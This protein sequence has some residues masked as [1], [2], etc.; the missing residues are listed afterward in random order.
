M[1]A[2]TI[3]LILCC[4]LLAGT[5]SRP[6]A[7][8]A[9]RGVPQTCDAAS[10]CAPPQQAPSQQNAPVL[11]PPYVFGMPR[12]QAMKLPG[13]ALGEGDF[14]GDILLP[15]ASF[16]GLPWTVRLEFRHDTL[17]RVSLMEAY[18]DARLTAV[19]AS[20]RDTGYEMLAMLAD[21]VRVDFVASLKTD[22]PE[23]LQKRI[24]KL[25][26]DKKRERMSYA[27]FDTR[28]MSRETKIMARNLSNL[29][30]VVEADTGEAEVSLLGDGKG[31]VSH[32]LV[33]F[34]L[35]VLELQTS[36]PER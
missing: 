27:W 17:V 23:A 8:P 29:L 32:I 24:K 31:G 5:P 15:E 35:P 36:S 25:H 1:R 22:G 16:A 20:L 9:G 6:Q 33:D 21:G 7:A 30:Q 4:L 3:L 10:E 18:S 2:T 11:F 14:A 13:A 28:K 12:A 34:T 26:T 19:N